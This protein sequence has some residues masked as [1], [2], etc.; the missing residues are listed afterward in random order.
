ML[1]STA[2]LL[3]VDWDRSA[4]IGASLPSY[5]R[6]PY[7]SRDILRLYR[8]FW[9]LVQR[10]PLADRPDAAFKLR[11]EFR[12]KRH[13]VGPKRVGKAFAAAQAQYNTL[14]AKLD[15]A[16][17]KSSGGLKHLMNGKTGGRQ[18]DVRRGPFAVNTLAADGAW[19]ALKAHAGGVVP[20]LATVTGSR[21]VRVSPH[22]SPFRAETSPSNN[23]MPQHSS[24]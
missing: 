5:S 6:F 15:D 8:D 16:D 18:G 2:T 24:R 23:S 22:I 11:N 1:R 13:I 17:V 9:R 7:R 3:R 12:S 20:N 19:S 4:I 21:N 14:K 10:L